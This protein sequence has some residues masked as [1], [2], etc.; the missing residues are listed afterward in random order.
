MTGALSKSGSTYTLA[1]WTATAS[2]V[3]LQ[4]NGVNLGA[5]P[6]TI[7]GWTTPADT[8]WPS[9]LAYPPSVY[10]Y[11]PS[12]SLVSNSLPPGAPSG[13]QAVMLSNSGDIQGCGV[14]YG[15]YLVSNSPVSLAAGDRVAFWWRAEKWNDW[16]SVF[17]YLLNVNTGAALTLLDVTSRTA[18]NWARVE[19]TV[20][21]SGTYRPV[22]VSGTWDESCGGVVGANLY[23]T[24][25]SRV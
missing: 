14:M 1:G 13:A 7:A 17:A 5:L 6:Q 9:S 23:V 8:T 18:T 24:G 12:V 25:V 22:F 19:A 11:T 15:P 20:P 3:Y 16:Y 2:P 4:K 10:S 21:V